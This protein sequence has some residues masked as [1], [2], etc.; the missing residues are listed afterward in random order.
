MLPILYLVTLLIFERYLS[1]YGSALRYVCPI[2]IAVVP[3]AIIL[4]GE[5]LT[6]RPRQGRRQDPQH[7]VALMTIALPTILVLWAFYGPLVN[8]IEQA[9]NHGSILSFPDAKAPL[10][11]NYSRF[12]MS[13][14][15]KEAVSEMQ[16][17]VPEGE[18]L[19]AWISLQLHLDYRR[20][21]IF[22][23]EPAGL[24]SPAQ[25]FPFDGDAEAAEEY[26]RRHGVRYVLW[27]RSGAVVRSDIGNVSFGSRLCENC[28][29]ALWARFSLNSRIS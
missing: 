19:L 16:H 29:R 3:A 22:S 4:A 15:A 10:F 12:A 26:F 23:V 11:L 14:E 24:V 21:P 13:D 25:D 8:R 20:N 7:L 27:Q 17:L 5:A 2:L 6:G 18:T 9:V 28:F 1:G